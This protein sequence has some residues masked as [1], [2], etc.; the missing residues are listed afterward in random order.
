METNSEQQQTLSPYLSP[1]AAWAFALGTSIGWGSLVVTSNTYLLQAGPWGSILGLLVGAV[2]ML[3]IGRNYHYLVNCFPDAGGAYTYSKVA[4]G[5]DYGFLTAWFLA[6]TYLAMFWANVTSLPLFARFFM[7]G[8]F[9]V[10][11]HYTVFGY[12]VYL[13]EA[14]LSMAAILIVALVCM[15]ARK[16]LAHVMVACVA[17]ICV[18]ITV[19]FIAAASGHAG[20]FGSF[21]PGFLPDNSALSQI[22]LIACISP[23]AFIGFENISH[24]SEE[25]TFSR[26]K[27]FRILAAAIAAA[28]VLYVFVFL[29]SVMAYP[30]EYG[31]WYEYLA[32]LGNLSGIAGL[33]PFYVAHH[34]LGDAGVYLL[35]GTLL[36]LVAT[37]LIAN[38]V[39]LSRLVYALAKDSVM[40]AVFAKINDRHIPA[41]AVVLVA[42][43]SL[44]IPFLGGSSTSPPL[45]PRSFTDSSRHRRSRW[46]G[47]ATIK[48]SRPQGASALSSWSSSVHTCCCRACSCRRRLPPSRISCSP[49]GPSSASRCSASCS[50]AIRGADSAARSWCGSPCFPL[51][52]S[53]PSCG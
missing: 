10:G 25:F 3:I 17:L 1:V 28:T 27:T 40:P 39:A 13:G 44:V 6:L 26:T 22:V 5:H 18:G 8:V 2:A 36:A 41:N 35:M 11:F 38:I 49:C 37:S 21:D 51:S 43:V 33:P 32:D 48:P 23:W 34:Y 46:H 15:R 30:P 45:G 52:C 19:C 29:L 24:L 42:V 53:S 47:R 14:L 50:R 7:D 20:Q 16:A 12:D 31:S 9:Q 4:F